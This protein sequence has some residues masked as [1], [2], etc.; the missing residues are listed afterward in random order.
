MAQRDR[1]GFALRALQVLG[2]RI[3]LARGDIEAETLRKAEQELSQCYQGDAT[4]V[5]KPS[6]LADLIRY[7]L[8]TS[9]PERGDNPAYARRLELLEPLLSSAHMQDPILR[10]D[11]AMLLF[12]CGRH[13]DANRAFIRMRGSGAYLDVPGSRAVRL[14]VSPDSPKPRLV[15]CVASSIGGA[16]ERVG[17]MHSHEFEGIEL[18]FNPHD[19]ERSRQRI[20]VGA[21]RSCHI[22]LRASGPLAVPSS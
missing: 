7:G 21:A 6:P 5:S 15:T 16:H 11:H 22:L 20:V 2:G 13:E 1:F 18:R 17:Y 9:A 8:F 12:Q 4:T 3:P 10:Y 19:F 14:T